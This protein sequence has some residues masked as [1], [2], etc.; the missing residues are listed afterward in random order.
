MRLITWNCR[1]GSVATRLAELSRLSPDVVFL[2]ECS[3]V[4]APP[5][6]GAV[7]TRRVN[8]SKGIALAVVSPSWCCEAIA[9]AGN[10]EGASIAGTISRGA[11]SFSVLGLWTRGK[12]VDDALRMIACHDAL[13]A[14][15]PTVVMGDLNSGTDLSK[16]G[17]PSRNHERLVGALESRGLVS[18]YHA[19]HRVEHGRETHATYYHR[20]DRRDR[21][22]IDF[23]FVPASWAPRIRRVVV[24]GSR[25]H[26]TSDHRP[27]CVEVGEE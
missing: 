9:V 15:G 22:H 6:G 14:A 16:R 23:C 21:W 27:V 25:S 24:P 13:F 7:L 20:F 8:A 17:S 19:F 26:A 2:Q 1:S 3:P 11:D 5:F 10:D 4:D 12:F 18:A